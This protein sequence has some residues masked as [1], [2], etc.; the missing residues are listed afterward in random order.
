MNDEY[1]IT[2]LVIQILEN[3]MT[4]LYR[5][6]VFF[7]VTSFIILFYWSSFDHKFLCN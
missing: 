7:T 5:Y 4:H 1:P 2:T 3:L 6:L